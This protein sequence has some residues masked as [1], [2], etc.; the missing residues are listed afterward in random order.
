MECAPGLD[1]GDGDGIVPNLTTVPIEIMRFQMRN[2]QGS[3]G[4]GFQNLETSDVILTSE[5]DF[6]IS[7][8][9]VVMNWVACVLAPII[10]VSLLK[11]L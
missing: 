1:T 11:S 4:K 8:T 2:S 7:F 3:H 5:E 9:V 10:K 6:H